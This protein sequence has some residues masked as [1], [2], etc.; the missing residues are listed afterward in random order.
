MLNIFDVDYTVLKKPTAWYFLL[1][2]MLEKLITFSQIKHLPAE[3]LRYK[4]GSPNQDFIEESVKHIAGIKQS[5]LEDMMKIC[6]EKRMKANIYTGALRLIKE[7]KDRGETVIF[8]TSS[9]DFMIEPL[10]RFF[11]VDAVLATV[12]EFKDGKTSGRIA[13]ESLFGGKKK[14]AVAEW[15][16]E[17]NIAPADIRFY[18]DSYTDIPLME[19]AGEAIAVNPDRFLRREAHKRGWEIVRFQEVLGSK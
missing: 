6:F 19:Y 3:W 4:L 17:R 5:E 7:M 11:G 16:A 15:L 8:A 18:S 2:A 12:L 14:E 9:F 13:G 1:E 10:E